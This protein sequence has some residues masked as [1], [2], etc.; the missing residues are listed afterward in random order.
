[1]DTAPEPEDT[2]HV[3]YLAT[4]TVGLWQSLIRVTGPC[5]ISVLF[6]ENAQH[7]V[8]RDVAVPLSAACSLG[9]PVS[10]TASVSDVRLQETSGSLTLP[11]LVDH[12]PPRLNV[13]VNT[14]YSPPAPQ[15]LTS[16]AGY[17]F[18]GD[19]MTLNVTAI[20]NH[21]LHGVYW[22][23]LP[24]GLRDSILSSD[25]GFS[26]FVS[27]PAQVGWSG[28]IQLRIYAKDASG[29]VSD[30]LASRPGAIQVGPTVSPPQTVTTIPGGTVDL[31]FDAKRAAIYLL[32][33]NRIAIFSPA[34]LSV[35]GTI[36]LP[37]YAQGFD[38]SASGDSI[39]TVLAGLRALGIV[40]LTGVSP[41]VTTV[42]LTPLD[43]AYRLQNIRV[44]STG[45]ALIVAQRSDSLVT[46]LFSYDLSSGTLR[47][48]V[49]A[50]SLGYNAKGQLERS[51]DG[52]VI[53]VNGVWASFV[54][55]DA[56]SDTFE[57]AQTARLQDAH[58]S[59]DSSG[60]HVAVYGDLYDASLQYLRTVGLALSQYG[61][62]AISP[63]GQTHYMVLVW[64]SGNYG[65]GRSRVSDGSMIDHI[66]IPLLI[67]LLRLSPDGSTLVVVGY[68]VNGP[69]IGLINLAQL[70]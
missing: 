5:D 29:N 57:P 70:H 69:K 52:G 19:T 62:D 54:R 32:Q 51:S 4:S 12:R 44:A 38:L 59:L 35:L 34:N 58:P 37:D 8:T 49:D 22:E 30:T 1:M 10:V 50:P 36:A 18:T 63:D 60:T 66:R 26:R 65:I 23:V 46:R 15:P 40:D 55:Y 68:D 56:N 3:S 21:A 20:D 61:P 31:A 67:D 14:P 45:R 2:L 27:I 33:G 53:I 6:P 17:L 47:Q 7:T 43:T 42:P 11:V 16:F 9:V 13:T 25:S 39:I 48:R 41:A 24:V 64:Q 28:P